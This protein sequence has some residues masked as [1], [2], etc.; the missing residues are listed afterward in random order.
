VTT[1]RV[2]ALAFLCAY[3]VQPQHPA[4]SADGSAVH[5]QQRLPACVGERDLLI[6]F[7]ASRTAAS[8]TKNRSRK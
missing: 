3:T 8:T 1:I 6:A 7:P 2:G 4:T 5:E